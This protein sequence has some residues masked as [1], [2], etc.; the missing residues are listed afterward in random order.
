[1]LWIAAA[2]IV[3]VLI[4]LVFFAGARMLSGPDED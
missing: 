1:M 3:L 2:W 4:I